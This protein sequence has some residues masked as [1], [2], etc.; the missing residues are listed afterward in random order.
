MSQRRM[1]AVDG[2][3]A[4]TSVA[5]RTNEVIVIYPITPS[6]PM[7]EVAEEWT[8]Q[9]RANIWGTIPEVT[10]MQSEGGAAGAC[11][12]SL[13][14][15]ALT[16]TFTASQGLLLM[17]PNMYKIAGELSPF[18][19]HVSARTLAT[20]ALSIFGDHSDVMSVRQTGFA[21]IASATVQ[22]AHDF[23]L[24]GQAATLRSRVPVLHFFDGFRTSH[25]VNKI[26]ELADEDL[27][28]MLPRD[29]IAAHRERALSPDAPKVRGTSQNPDTFFQMQEARN[30]Y[31]A[32]MPEIVQ[33]VMDEFAAL[34]GRRY[35]LFD[36]EGDPEAEKVIV[37]MASGAETCAKVSKF[38]NTKG[39]KTGVLKVRLY[40]PFSV[41]HFVSALPVSTRAIA[42]LD[43][44]KEHGSI[45]EPLFMD[46]VSALHDAKA[47]GLRPTAVEPTV[48]GGRYGLS[49]KEFTPSHVK[50]IFDEL[51]RETPKPRFTVGIVDD[52]T[53]LSLP[54]DKA[55]VFAP[56]GLT[57]CVFWGLG[58][59]GTVGAN[60]NSIKIIAEQT[61]NHAQAYFVYDSKKAGAVTVSHL[62]FSDR[63]IQSPY[64]IEQAE[65]LA[66]HQ[67]HFMEKYEILEQAAP[68][69]IFLLNSPYG[70]DE[71]WDK[72]PR[73]AQA[74]MIERKL[75]FFVIDATHVAVNAGM[76]TRI[77]TVMQTCFFAISGVLPR[78][79]AIAN[80][81]QA[82]EKTYG[83]KGRDVVEKNFAA[84][85]MTLD[86]LHEVTVPDAVTSDFDLPPVVPDDAPDFVQR[87]TAMMMARKGDL[88]PV[89]AFPVDGTWPVGT[90]RYEKRNIAHEI[91]VWIPELCIQCNK[92][93]M[94]CPHSAIRVKAFA[95]ALAEAAPPTFKSMPYKGKEFGEALYSIQVAPEDCTGCGVCVR[96][97]PGKDKKTGELSLKMEAMPPKGGLRAHEIT[98]W[99]F[100][101]TLPEVDR[102]GLRTNVKMSQFL[103]P[104]IEFPG[105]C[106]GCG[107][108][109][110]VKLATQMFGDRMLIA[111][112]TGCSSIYGGNLPTAP[113]TTDC[114]GRGPTWSNSLFEDNAEFGLGFRLAINQ[115]RAN[116]EGLLKTLSGEVGDA[117]VGELLRAVQT[118]EEGLAKQRERIDALRAKL[119]G[120]DRPEARQLAELADYLAKKSV[121]IVGG[122]GWAYD[123]GYGGLDHV[124]STGDDVNILVM[125]TEVYSNTGGQQSKATTL[126][127]AA[128]FA[129][130]GKA[131]PKK[132]LGLMAI[133]Y[134][135]VYVAS[136]AYGAKDAQ[137]VRAFEEAEAFDGPS[138][139]I[140]YSHCIEHGYDLADGLDQQK[141]AVESGYWPLYRYDPRRLGTGAPALQLDGGPIKA[142]LDDYMKNETRFQRVR[143]RDPARYDNL[144]EQA[145]R[146]LARRA[147]VYEK[148]SELSVGPSLGKAAE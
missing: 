123:I 111:N 139:L 11:H 105:A 31:H 64:L 116:A 144:V 78:D 121:W 133:A 51:G 14:A 126:G 68:G 2:N 91:P 96:V 104:L 48:I 115:H 28:A 88:L 122:D 127:A 129:V 30:P 36:Y 66:C 12:G 85:D 80:I 89:S 119:A 37:V 147:A 90:T 124:I 18:C 43:R 44:T 32:A 1:I 100:F 39:E 79:E 16:T 134:G 54:E 94:V 9:K 98:N 77:N 132:D 23:A 110:Y 74:R 87:V 130:T 113:F 71:I 118:N 135:N 67:F 73:S 97:C 55:F 120:V 17:I 84:V 34:T 138:L 109:P 40:R 106:S 58:A 140:A 137:T 13:Q 83:S 15:G 10:E 25:E 41:D 42:V 75:R 60:K 141:L 101:L 38:L 103:A 61:D 142:D 22:E 20:H 81:K 59:D 112:A 53:G 52:V 145:K 93:V 76:G 6:S 131:R 27:D 46:V 114:H 102:V 63:P 95:P 143:Q 65:F 86:N 29:L 5:H 99:D 107:E 3:E 70:A 35:G 7:G 92:C 128:K 50:S 148:L 47:R 146:D 72:L 45:G 26:E 24:I 125:D 82:I 136:I 33:Q 108:T 21:M 56:S 117:L 69:G 49:S 62:R 4:V 57:R 19:M 8:A